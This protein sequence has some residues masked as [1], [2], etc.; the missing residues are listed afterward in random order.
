MILVL[1]GI[2]IWR[3]Q[4]AKKAQEADAVREVVVTKA[5]IKD[6][7]DTSGKIVSDKT[8]TLNF[9]SPGKLAYVNT[10]EGKKTTR[11][12]VLLSLDTGELK[13]AERGAYYRYLAADANAKQ[14]EDEVKDHSSD[15]NFMMK[16]KR[17]AAQTARD[18]AYDGWLL[19]QKNLQY[20]YL[21]SPF[22]GVVLN[23]TVDAVGDTV[24]LTDGVTVVDPDNLHFEGEVDEGDVS[25]MKVGQKVQLK[26]DAFEGRIFVGT[27]KEIGF[28]SKISSTGATVY[29]LQ[30]AVEK[31]EETL[32]LGMNG[33]AEVI[34]M[35]KQGVL[36]L[37]VEAVEDNKVTLANGEVR[38][39]KTGIEDL[40][41]I[42]IIEGLNEGDKVVIK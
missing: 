29:P 6:I 33:D 34:I 23:M 12:Q 25:R 20:A 10:G 37:P 3:W 8:A 26:L 30:I 13:I 42:E 18:I 22:A 19:A 27:V 38:E 41:S 21:V 5:D 28:G 36:V 24:S 9:Q 40:D 14:V 4:A 11:G 15:E 17:V 39:V 31:G 1:V 7:V 35:E 32:R 2:G 16:N